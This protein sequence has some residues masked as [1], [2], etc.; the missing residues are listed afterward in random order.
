MPYERDP[1]GLLD[2]LKDYSPIGVHV[3]TSVLGRGVI[4]DQIQSRQAAAFKLK[5]DKPI[6]FSQYA[7][8]VGASDAPLSREQIEDRWAGRTIPF[9][10]EFLDSKPSAQD[11]LRYSLESS[12]QDCIDSRDRVAKI[13]APFRNVWID[14]DDLKRG[15]FVEYVMESGQHTAVLPGRVVGKGKSGRSVLMEVFEPITAARLPETIV[16]E[17]IQNGFFSERTWAISR[18][19]FDAIQEIA[20]A[21]LERLPT[22]K[23]SDDGEEYIMQELVDLEL[24]RAFC[25]EHFKNEALCTLGAATFFILPL[26][27]GGT[28]RPL[29]ADE[30]M[31]DYY[32]EGFRVEY[33]SGL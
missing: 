27:G 20:P 5:L 15:L 25:E 31:V 22:G 30:Q 11:I 12:C 26:G 2:V 7:Q 21:V 14:G 8:M 33:E 6:S 4:E 28:F 23:M 32:G 13:V 16:P 10:D 18:D 17:D 1:E 9:S 24:F 19:T 29:R 3:E